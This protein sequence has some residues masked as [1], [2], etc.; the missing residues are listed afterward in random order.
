[1]NQSPSPHE[2]LKFGQL[3]N[4][5]LRFADAEGRVYLI[6]VYET[7]LIRVRFWPA[8]V[9]DPA[10]NRTWSLVDGSGMCPVE[11]HDRHALDDLGRF[12][13]PA[14]ALEESEGG[15]RLETGKLRLAVRQDTFGI[16][17]SD[18]DGQHL[19][20]DNPLIGYGLNARLRRGVSHVLRRYA[21]EHYYGFGEKS[22][23]L[24][25]MSR[26]MR[27]RNTDAFGYDAELSDPLYKHVPFY[28]TLRDA[29]AFGLFYDTPYDCEFDM[30][31]EIDNYYGDYRVFQADGGD[32]DY[33][34]IY[35]PTIEHVVE[36][37]TALTGRNPLPPRWTLGYFNS[38]MRYAE[39]PNAQE[40]LVEFVTN[41][42][43]HDIPCSA[44]HLGSGYSKAADG[45]RY[46][47]A[48]NRQSVPDPDRMTRT[49]H[50]A[51]MRV[52]A[53]IKPAML[54]THPRF[55]EACDLFIRD[56][57]QNAPDL[58]PFWGG[59]GAHLDFTN[60]ATFAWWKENIKEQLLAQGVD[61]AWNDNNEYSVRH[62]AARCYG[63][64]SGMPM[65]ACRP[66]QTLLMGMASYQAQREYAPA[67]RTFVVT[68]AGA[69]GLQ[70]YAAT[71]TG[72]NWTSWKTLRYNIPMGLGL[73]LSGWAHVGHD[74]GGFG[75]GPPDPELFV[76]WMQNAAFHPRCGVNS[77]RI[78]DPEPAPWM[79]AEVIPLVR[80]ILRFRYRLIPY[81][82]SLFWESSRTGH[83]VI[84]PLVYQFQGDP[85]CHT[86]SCD[87]MLGPNQLVASVLEARA[88]T[89][90]VY[91]P[92]GSAWYDWHDGDYFVGGD[93]VMLEAPLERTPL[94]AREGGIIPTE[95]NGVTRLY[96][97]P[98]RKEGVGTFDLFRTTGSLS[99]T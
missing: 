37:Y 21:D 47:F 43:K 76:R 67:R 68:R 83:P 63:F 74:V 56:A 75:G 33:Y 14:F 93:C 49:F 16:T 30:G 9:P 6:S 7:D 82:Y 61:C 8:G 99:T 81:F 59:Q 41:C 18:R 34:L 13:R 88:R 38:G 26:R 96:A 95:E 85:L 97:F 51:G 53:N 29:G 62:D 45:K 35:G 40:T 94:L 28:I 91:L 69:P 86:E 25:K 19:A 84:R 78:E 31:A 54:T 36:Q 27:M 66:I 71:W 17:W 72:D 5:D 12:T 77:W 39:G 4:G 80:E 60:P 3:D 10:M 2:R 22:G 42:K 11:G 46:V 70:R 52:L 79:H 90:A 92:K 44:F 98:H 20:E 57:E 1:M 15:I 87:F 48:W 89:R 55:D 64:G 24:D 73:S 65:E 23:P 58:A 50:D 32:L